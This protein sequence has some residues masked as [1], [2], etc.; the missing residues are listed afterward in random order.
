MKAYIAIQHRVGTRWKEGIELYE[1]DDERIELFEHPEHS[2]LR[3]YASD[4][5]RVDKERA[6]R[7]SGVVNTQDFDHLKHLNYPVLCYLPLRGDEA[8]FEDT[9]EMKKQ[10][11]IDGWTYMAKGA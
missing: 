5:V 6:Y 8:L 10:R 11:I 7:Y 9:I 2:H 4:F 1:L 3:R